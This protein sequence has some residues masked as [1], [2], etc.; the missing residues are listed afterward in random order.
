MRPV[1]C[2]WVEMQ[3]HRAAL[4]NGKRGDQER[5]RCLLGCVSHNTIS[6]WKSVCDIL[7]IIEDKGKCQI[8]DISEFQP[9]HAVALATHHRKQ[10]GKD[11]AAWSDEVK[12]EIAE[13]VERIEDEKLTVQGLRKALA[14]QN[15]TSSITDP[16]TVED[17]RTLIT[18][19]RT[20][21]TIYADPPWQYSNQATRSA[22][23]NHYKTLR[24]EDICSLPIRELVAEASHL[25]L[26]TTNGFLPDALRVIDAWGFT[27]KSCFIW[28]K[29]QLGIGN[30]WRVSHEFLLLGVRGSCPFRDKSL[31]SWA[32]LKRSKHSSKPE[33]VRR[34]IEAVSPGPNL[35]LFG[36]RCATNWTVWGDQIERS[37]FDDDIPRR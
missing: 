17:L 8:S 25:H 23:D 36:R 16:C 26:W 19:G 22:T 4:A 24:L 31:R 20:F 13:W 34:F 2:S 37:M 28:C 30:Y 21:G 7:D 32:E 10:H 9:S 11:A 35:E 18:K 6:T 14:D 12:D 3:K 5:L 33:E 1:K 29:P 15:G 27:Y